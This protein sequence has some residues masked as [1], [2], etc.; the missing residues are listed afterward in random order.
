MAQNPR[1]LSQLRVQQGKAWGPPGGVQ[2]FD[3]ILMKRRFQ[4]LFA[5]ASS[6]PYSV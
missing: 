4:Q 6:E 1:G 3:P 5:R 2:Q